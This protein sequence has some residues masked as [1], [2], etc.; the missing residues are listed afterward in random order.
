MTFIYESKPLEVCS[1]RPTR[2][3]YDLPPSGQLVVDLFLDPDDD[4]S[5]LALFDTIFCS[6]DYF[7]CFCVSETHHFLS[8]EAYDEGWDVIFEDFASR[9]L[10]K[11]QFMDM[12]K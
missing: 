5:V 4:S 10:K 3:L 11:G 2:H 8:R 9:D 1:S 12:T 6:R 7:T